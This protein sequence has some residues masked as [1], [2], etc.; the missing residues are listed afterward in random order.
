MGIISNRKEGRTTLFL[1]G[2]KRIQKVLR[3]KVKIIPLKH[4]PCYIASTDAS[5]IEDRLIAAACL[6]KY[7]ELI[8]IKEVTA[9]GECVI[10][11]V[12]G[13]LSFREGPTVL[14]AIEKLGVVPDLVIFDGHGIAHPEG[15]GIASHI[16]VLLDIPSIG[17]AKSK[18]VGGFR[19]P[20]KKKGQW[21][22]LT[23]R[24]ETVAAVLR[25]RDNV[26][27]VFV[28]PGHRI[29]LEGAIRIILGCTGRYRIPEPLRC[30]DR[31]A[32]RV[33][34]VLESVHERQKVH[35]AYM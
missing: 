33:K 29:D 9:E 17:C 34:K 23:Y 32:G 18:L 21:S 5:F 3:E 19:E 8:H 11:Y 30:A 10:P 27:P 7:P 28:S 14:K 6:F 26:K 20:G 12:P 4:T 25:T 35:R 16:G 31:A 1:E 24:G 15:M 2:A 22:G 13:Y